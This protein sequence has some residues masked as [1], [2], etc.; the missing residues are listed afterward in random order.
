MDAYSGSAYKVSWR[1]CA[2]DLEWLKARRG[3]YA[4]IVLEPEVRSGE[5][6]CL[7]VWVRWYRP[8]EE[9]DTAWS[10]AIRRWWPS[11]DYNTMPELIRFMVRQ[12][13]KEM[14]LE[15]RDRRRRGEP[16]LGAEKAYWREVLAT[17]RTLDQ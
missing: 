9:R 10:R 1:E 3:G 5:R 14:E 6:S 2:S 8:G 15:E 11:P 13:D 7:L 17:D 12:L 4:R 16:A